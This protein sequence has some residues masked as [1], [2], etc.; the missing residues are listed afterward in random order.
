MRLD[1]VRPSVE[2]SG[3]MKE[4]FF[5]IEDQGM[6]FEILRNKMYSDPIRAICR[7]I[8]CN[9][10]DAHREVGT[11]ERPIQITLPNDLEPFYKVKDWGPG[12]SPERM[13]NIFIRYAA[14]TKRSDNL[15]TGGFGL[16][17]KTPFSYSDT[18]TILTVYNG[19]EYN[20]A[21]FIDE[22]KV[23]KLA[24]LSS[25][26]TDKDNGTELIIPANKYHDYNLFKDATYK[27]TKHWDVKPIIKGGSINYKEDD[28]PVISGEGWAVFN[29]GWNKDTKIIIDG[30]EY[31]IDA[32]ELRKFADRKLLDNCSAQIR[33]YFGV[34]ELTLA[35]N[36]EQ[37]YLDNRTKSMIADRILEMKNSIKDQ[38]E[39]RLKSIDNLWNAQIFFHKELHGSFSNVEFL[40]DVKWNGTILTH[41]RYGL[42]TG[43]PVYTFRKEPFSGR[44][45]RNNNNSKISFD[46]NALLVVNDTELEEP[47]GRYFKKYFEGNTENKLIFLICPTATKTEEDLNKDINLDKMA[48]KKLSSLISY[49]G[50]KQSLRARLIVFKF[51]RDAGNFGQIKV[52][53]FD[54]SNKNKILVR[55][56]KDK[57][58]PAIKHI[59]GTKYNAS[60]SIISMLLSSFPN[61]EFYGVDVGIKDDR[62]EESLPGCGDYDEFVEKNVINSGIDFVSAKSVAR[63]L[64]RGY[65][66]NYVRMNDLL[67][68]EP[69]IKDTDSIFARVCTALKM[70]QA[71]VNDSQNFISIYESVSSYISGDD[72]DEYLNKNP[73]M[74][75]KTYLKELM[76]NYPMLSFLSG[77]DYNNNEKHI[78]AYINMVD[79]N[80]E[81]EN[82]V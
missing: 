42:R 7:E 16:G 40:G 53:D 23:G 81:K 51:N 65:D 82:N 22:T 68:I 69:L 21:C 70:L 57:F 60:N 6:I 27:S 18:F 8:S 31:P 62:V 74:S 2:S 10:R 64:S 11:P 17:A 26:P 37:V 25:S 19:V 67:K 30:I 66:Y 28:E 56:E 61:L 63:G 35:A 49:K 12:I 24:L 3:G 14:S 46:E 32:S 33:L 48:P 52:D 29:E 59:S 13:V 15:Q 47:T 71:I 41:S 78:A 44:I 73:H 50:R 72:A 4:E 1:D 43:C 5:S 55:L 76:D 36:R 58:N 80:K 54:T 75:S 20:Y 38:V 34:G 77:S 79:K 39:S 45:K 9:A